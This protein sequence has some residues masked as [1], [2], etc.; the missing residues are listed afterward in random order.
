LLRNDE[1]SNYPLSFSVEDSGMGF[2]LMGQTPVSVNAQ[3]I[4]EY[5]ETTLESLADALESRPNRAVRD[6][7]VLPA[8][9]REKAIYAWG[10]TEV[11]R[12]RCAHELF[13]DLVDRA[14]HAIAVASKGALLS[15]SEL[16][17]KANQLAHYL[18]EL[19]IGPDMRVGIYLERDVESVVALL[20]VLK[21]GAAYVPLDPTYPIGRLQWMLQDSQATVLLTQSH[22]RAISGG[23]GEDIRVVEID[24]D[25]PAWNAKPQ[26]NP[27]PQRA[28][29]TPAHLA[30][31]IYTSGST[32]TPK[33]VMVEHRSVCNLIK[34]QID[35]FDVEKDSR[36][37]QFASFSF[38][39]SVS[40][41][42]IA[43]CRGAVLCFAPRGTVLVG[44]DLINAISCNRISH[45]TLPPA[46]LAGLSHDRLK[47]VST[48]ISAGETLSGA[49][50]KRW[51]EGRD[52]INAYGPTEAT[53]CATLH[54]HRA[55][56]CGDP[57]IGRPIANARVYILDDRCEPIPTGA[58]GE[59]YIGGA[60]VARG[61]FSQPAQ[62]ADRF[63]PDPFAE[64]V[65]ARMYRTGDIGSWRDDGTI[66]LI[67]RQ[68]SQVKIRGYR[69]ELG[70]I[71]ARLKEHKDVGQVVVIAREDQPGDKRL[72]AYYTSSSIGSTTF[73]AEE[74]RTHLSITLP[75]YMV[76]AAYVC[77]PEFPLTPNGKVDR[78]ALPLPE[79]TAY[80]SGAYEAPQGEIETVVA[81][82]WAEVLQIE[83]VGRRDDFF[84]LGG[85][86]LRAVHVVL[87]L[88][89]ALKAEVVIEDLFDRPVLADFAAGLQNASRVAA[90]SIPR[91]DRSG[92]ISLSFAQ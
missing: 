60:G 91:I 12:G 16:N 84:E 41:M 7:E 85:H 58:Q 57:S 37:L 83:R 54:K 68:D 66:D 61:Y 24:T 62:T 8:A 81:A 74:L 25:V 50:A 65:G 1:R 69:V 14:P 79:A 32:G 10:R 11:Q 39:A 21:A 63:V 89:Q 90:P 9:E 15:Y 31:V 17:T 38:D 36:I 40:E 44:E 28:G 26:S 29:L 52:L 53:V 35:E 78:R 27:A 45:V 70:E 86:S 30:Y 43:L 64:E 73:A 72:V 47:S 71:E 51:A 33:G 18:R 75:E 49:L 3:R 46:V 23:L 80:S 2:K 13:E 5:M 55:E 76:P 67:G 77:L 42:M 56:D 59:L 19:Q 87:R 22:L 82:I 88:Q 6:L 48:L 20:A 34:A 92:P 4:C